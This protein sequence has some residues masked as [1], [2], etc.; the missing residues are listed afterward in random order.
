MDWSK[1]AENAVKKVPFFV[2]KRVKLGFSVCKYTNC[3]RS[4]QDQGLRE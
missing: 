1:E 4:A 2:R 3:R